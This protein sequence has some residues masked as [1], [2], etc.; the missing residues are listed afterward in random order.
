MGR[1]RPGRG[2]SEGSCGHR[3]ET[4]WAA[5]PTGGLSD[6]S[7]KFKYR[8]VARVAESVD[9]RDSKSLVQ[10]TYEF[11]SRPG[12]SMPAFAFVSERRFFLSPRQPRK[13]NQ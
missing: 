6:A 4:Q 1:H 9:A 7:M 8:I 11:E 2:C 10:C 5:C 13:S 12:Y 3:A